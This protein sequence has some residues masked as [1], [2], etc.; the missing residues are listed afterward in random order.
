VWSCVSSIVW[1]HGAVRVGCVV[2]QKRFVLWLLM[3]CAY[4]IFRVYVIC[5]SEMPWAF[6]DWFESLWLI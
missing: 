3:Y 1:A 4:W 6:H 5:A 2:G